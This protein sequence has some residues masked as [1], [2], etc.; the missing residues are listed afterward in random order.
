MKDTV[1]AVLELVEVVLLVVL[2]M[3]DRRLR[4]DVHRMRKVA[5]P[6]TSRKVVELPLREERVDAVR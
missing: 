5:T 1:F 3:S 2:L 4:K 6:A